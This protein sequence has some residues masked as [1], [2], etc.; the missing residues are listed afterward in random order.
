TSAFG[1]RYLSL[2]CPL[3]LT[4]ETPW[5]QSVP[6]L[7]VV[8]P[9]LL[10]PPQPPLHRPPDPGRAVAPRDPV[11]HL[12]DGPPDLPGGPSRGPLFSPPGPPCVRTRVARGD[13]AWWGSPPPQVRT[14]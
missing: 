8:E 10:V 3:G 9:R 7:P 12:A 5:W 6:P 1:G 2:L 13:G 4:P 11:Q 14:W